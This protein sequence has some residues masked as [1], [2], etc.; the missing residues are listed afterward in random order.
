MLKNIFRLGFL[1]LLSGFLFACSD[2]ALN[3]DNIQ[4][5]G[6]TITVKA[7][8][9]HLVS[10][11]DTLHSIPSKIKDETFLV[12]SITDKVF[13]Q[14]NA[15]VLAQFTC[16]FGLKLPANVDST[17]LTLELKLNDT[18]QAQGDSIVTINV[19]RMNKKTFSYRE[20]LF[21][22]INPD[23]YSD[24]HD[25]LGTMNFK[26]G[27]SSTV[28][29][30]LND[31]L[32]KQLMD[33][34]QGITNTG[35]FTNE[36]SFTNFLNGLYISVDG[37]DIM[38][39][40]SG[41]AMLSIYQMNMYL[42]SRYKNEAGTYVGQSSIFPANKEV[43]QV[44][45]IW[46][47]YTRADAGDLVRLD[48][49]EYLSSP[50]GA[51]TIITIPL[52]KIKQKYG[53][54]VND[55]GVACLAN[56]QMLSVNSAIL[57]VQIADTTNH[58]MTVP[59]YLLLI[60]KSAAT[61]F[62]N[63]DKSIDYVTSVM[64]AYDS[65][66]Q[67]YSFALHDYLANELKSATLTENSTDELLLI[68]VDAEYSTSTFAYSNIKYSSNFYGTSVCSAKHPTKPMKLDVVISGF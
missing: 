10:S 37:G 21:S 28:V 55:K 56:G 59:P 2:D 14:T 8:T 35:I 61:A 34:A 60:K 18:Y 40:S 65:N 62:F 44:N 30:P 3:I 17:S 32:K 31:A 22:N 64:G 19:Y 53:I 11:W 24:M 27:S 33:E 4:P 68:P 38:L 45:R 13:G 51:N 12:G 6:D 43:R 57:R 67:S 20:P 39:S 58:L 16:P 26:A 46:H 50:A 66:T 48:E 1:S 47:D 23:L 9:F 63:Q 29:I 5:A 49:A 25:L 36:N 42:F 7:D 52:A 54:Y 15:E 41:S